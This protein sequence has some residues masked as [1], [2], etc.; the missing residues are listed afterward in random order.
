MRIA[1]KTLDIGTY[2]LNFDLIVEFFF[3]K[4]NKGHF[5]LSYT[6]TTSTDYEIIKISE[7][8]KNKIL[9]KLGL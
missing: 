6:S 2:Y 9:N 4:K 3:I 8:E 5:I 1:V 7:E